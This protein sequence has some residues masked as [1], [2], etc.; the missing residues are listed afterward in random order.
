M[1]IKMQSGVVA[2]T[3]STNRG[4][5]K[6]GDL[7]EFQVSLAYRVSYRTV[8]YAGRDCI[9]NKFLPHF[10]NQYVIPSKEI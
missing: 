6:Q 8:S 3:F 9:K 5:K 1:T 10:P 2:H 7:Y 4:R